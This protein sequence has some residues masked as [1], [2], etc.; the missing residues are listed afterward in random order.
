MV[1]VEHCSH[2][3]K[4]GEFVRRYTLHTNWDPV[5]LPSGADVPKLFPAK[6]VRL[7]FHAD[8]Q[9]LVHFEA[10]TAIH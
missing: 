5:P 9:Y 7:V 1:T 8:P 6:T 4:V 2:D 3:G 10:F